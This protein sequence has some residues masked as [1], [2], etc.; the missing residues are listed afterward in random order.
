M[1]IKTTMSYHFTPVRMTI[2]KNTNNKCWLGYREKPSNSTPGYMSKKYKN[3]T[4]KDT[5][6]PMFIAAL[7]V[8]AKV[9][10]V[11]N[12]FKCPT[13]DEW[14]K[15]MWYKQWNTTEL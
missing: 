4:Q 14:I 1:P 8:T 10:K 11:Y 9:V 3:T 5:G 13:I 15:K 12:Q 6:T 2:K 7:F